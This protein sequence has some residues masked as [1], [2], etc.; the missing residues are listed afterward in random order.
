MKQVILRQ[1]AAVVEQV[2][3]PVVEPGTV[4]VAVDHSCISVGTELSGLR[5]S[6]LPLW[7]RALRQ[8]QNVRKALQLMVSAGP[9]RTWSLVRGQ[10]A[11]GSP[12]GY[13]AS[14]V[15]LEA[16]P[17]VEDLEAGERVAC[18]GAQYA[19]HAEVI[20]VPRNLVVP[21]P[22]GV[23]PR[24]A[25]TVTLG[26]IALQGVRRAEPT[27]GETFVVVGLGVLGQ[28]TAQL[29]KA[30]GTRVIA[31]DLD[32]ERV[33]LALALGADLGID[34]DEEL[35][36]E[37]VARLTDG[38]GADGV[39]ITAATSS[40]AV[41]STAFR[42][43]RRKGR[44]VLVGDVGLGLN[45][46]DFYAKEIDFRISCSYGPGR[47][48]RRYE[49][50]GLDYPVAYVRW[51]ENRNMTE[52]LRLLEEGRVRLDRLIEKIYPL[53]QAAEAYGVLNGRGR[54]PLMV[55]LSYPVPDVAQ[56]QRRIA[57]PGAR[58]GSSGR[59]RL[60]LIGA[61]GFAKA[62]HLPNLRGMS[63]EVELRA[64]VSR[65]G[66]N[67]VA[68]ARMFGAAYG[69][70]E[71]D[72][73][74]QDPEVDAVLI[75]TRHH[76][77]AGLVLAALQAGKHVLVE[78]PLCLSARELAEVTGWYSA[79]GDGAPILLTGFNR[80][81][82]PY[83]SAT[84]R[85]LAGRSGPLLLDYRMNAGYLPLDHWTQGPEGGGRNIGEACHIYDFATSLI[86]ARVRT[87]KAAA[88]M[89]TTH[90][91]SP[92]DNF[93]ATCAFE[94]GSLMTLCYTA[95]GNRGFP[96]EQYDLFVD[97]KVIEMRDYTR[98]RCY[99]LRARGLRT[100]VPEKGQREELGAFVSAIRQGGEWPIPLWEQ[101][102]AMEIAFAVEAQLPGKT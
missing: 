93:V 58:R 71:A 7:K 9:K 15:V 20:R 37:Q 41:V 89:P 80:R 47:Y 21:V 72:Q 59:V 95:M 83:A 84:R 54:K 65:T 98:L 36:E 102:Q 64:V 23:P 73:V 94:D 43:C 33:A 70:T 24:E 12:S 81:F 35:P 27:L 48:D 32:P 68:T 62:M 18:A 44:V 100:A 34:P 92:R 78:K 10:L 4:L 1:G 40:D 22:A 19:H 76:L 63:R 88:V 99:G 79:H 38:I 55:L 101:V 49:E 85:A 56:P 60:A 26:A 77:H 2:P 52:Y 39:I 57:I 69:T 8:P 6:G 5:T 45:R 82:S 61:G 17:G 86:G 13:S 74:W 3:A 25:S 91:Y 30:N 16:G 11:G 46:A 53:E 42:M 97:G 90:Y 87:V 31:L 29:L 51:T 67:A 14:G 50:E 96:K 75:A 28:L 66:H